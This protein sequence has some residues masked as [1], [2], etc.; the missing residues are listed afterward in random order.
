MRRISG[1]GCNVCGAL[2]G[3]ARVCDVT[4]CLRAFV[5]IANSAV[6][7][8]MTRKLQGGRTRVIIQMN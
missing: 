3:W 8:G 7:P 5:R 4:N 2:R 1:R 6:L